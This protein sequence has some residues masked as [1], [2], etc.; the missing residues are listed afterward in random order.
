[1]VDFKIEKDVEYFGQLQ[2]EKV[3][4]DHFSADN[5]LS[6]FQFDWQLFEI[7]DRSERRMDSIQRFKQSFNVWIDSCDNCLLW[8]LFSKTSIQ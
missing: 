2:L 8:K 1:M 4:K 3:Y 6:S 7:S 5:Y